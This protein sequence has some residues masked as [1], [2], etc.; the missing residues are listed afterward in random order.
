MNN[1]ANLTQVERPVRP[2]AEMAHQLTKRLDS[3][4][5]KDGKLED[6]DPQILHRT[7]EDAAVFVTGSMIA[8]QV[9]E[10]IEDGMAKNIADKIAFNY[11]NPRHW[12]R[13]AAKGVAIAAGAIGTGVL[14]N[15]GMRAVQKRT[16]SAD[17]G[18]SSRKNPFADTAGFESSRTRRAPSQETSNTVH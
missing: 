7:V 17:V 10:R 6:I 15:Y 18:K 11:K 5:N 2:A 12:A 3:L 14:L 8:E 1:N 9:M 16:G 13:E 4:F